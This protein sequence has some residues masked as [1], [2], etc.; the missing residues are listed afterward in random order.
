MGT[1]GKTA[2]LMEVAPNDS[3]FKL[4]VK[5]RYGLFAGC[6]IIGMIISGMGADSVSTNMSKFIWCYFGGSL[7]ALFSTIFI[8]GPKK[9]FIKMFDRKRRVASITFFATAILTI[10]FGLVFQSFGFMFLPYIISYCALFWYAIS[11]IPMCQTLVKGCIKGCFKCCG[12]EC[13]C[14]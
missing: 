10:L 1:F 2:K 5:W 12:L 7:L 4:P 11:F 9:Q 13:A 14:L 8:M 3:P 6:F